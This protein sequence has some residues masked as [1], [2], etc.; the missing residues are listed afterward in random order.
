MCC[1]GRKSYIISA[2]PFFAISSAIWYQSLLGDLGPTLLKRQVDGEAADGGDGQ[3]GDEVGLG[4]DGG[5]ALVKRRG[6]RGFARVL[7]LLDRVG[8][9]C[10]RDGCTHGVDGQ[11]ILHRVVD[12]LQYHAA[13]FGEGAEAAV[14]ADAFGC[15]EGE[16]EVDGDLRV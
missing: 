15:F 10:G 1:T 4:V 16:L 6:V 14:A 12:D 2:A 3:A 11:C 9:G 5:D 8:K 7:H 13:A